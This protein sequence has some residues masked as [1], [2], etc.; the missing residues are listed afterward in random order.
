M[1]TKQSHLAKLE[2]STLGHIHELEKERS[3][4]PQNIYDK[5]PDV[6]DRITQDFIKLKK[7]HQ[8]AFIETGTAAGDTAKA[9]M[10]AGFLKVDT[11]ELNPYFHKYATKVLHDNPSRPDWKNKINLFQGS[12][13]DILPSVLEKNTEPFVLWLDAHWSGGPWIGENMSSYLPKELTAIAKCNVD[14]TDC[15]ILI[16]DMNHFTNDKS[17]IDLI[18]ILLNTIKPNGTVELY[19]SLHGNTF[20][21]SL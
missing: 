11:I 10:H 20:M 18:E 15:S 17:F 2:L 14:F 19:N 13:A 9:A 16:D 5:W 8:T 12:S 4:C 3:A 6:L 7:P 1:E 21:T